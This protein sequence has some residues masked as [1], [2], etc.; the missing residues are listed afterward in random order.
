MNAPEN[1]P[2]LE[3]ALLAGLNG[4]FPARSGIAVSG[5]GDSLAL[6]HL[7]RR[8]AARQGAVIEAVTVD[9]GLRPESA[10]E[11]LAVARIAAELG[12]AHQILRWQGPA[13]TG[14]LMD[15]ARR[16]R[17]GLIGAW[18]Q[19]R[20]LPDILLGHTA[21]DDAESFLLNLGRAAGLEGVSG[22]RR[23]FCAEGIRWHRPLL[24]VSR[25]ALRACLQAGGI[26]WIE[27]PSNDDPRF[28][29]VRARRA[30]AGLAPLG[31]SVGTLQATIGH[32]AAARHALRATL[33]AWVAQNVDEHA[34]GLA[35]D[36][37]A[38]RDLDP[39]LRR[40]LLN[41]AIL[42]MSGADYPPRGSSIAR[43]AARI[44][45]G[46]AA[47]T[48]A[49]C[50]FVLRQGR[51]QICRELRAVGPAIPAGSALWDHRWRCSGPS[52]PGAEIRALGPG[53]LRLCPEWRE[54]APREVL[55]TSPSIWL[56]GQLLAAPLA[57]AGDK[58]QATT[59][60]P[61]VMFILAH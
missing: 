39:E 47:T 56:G 12:V 14:N 54:H 34:G 53:G 33:A 11:A 17:L 61:F 57:R 7:A 40:M 19:G 10:K 42:W 32:L 35:L 2:E 26:S 18:A 5:G 31:I 23:T 48:L 22:M 25:A 43:L 6:L 41:R 58:W 13:A 51:L 36:L 28:H 16:A 29:R 8:C 9:H 50:R 38:V 15:Q 1:A 21:D 24:S 52:V 30:L 59:A 55:V 3:A 27:D 44:L 4:E 49:G 60:K 45:A 37:A 46:Q 20:G